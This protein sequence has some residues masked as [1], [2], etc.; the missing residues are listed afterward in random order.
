V[1]TK[2][3]KAKQAAL[4][5]YWDDQGKLLGCGHGSLEFKPLWGRGEATQAEFLEYVQKVLNALH[6]TVMGNGHRHGTVKF[7][8]GRSK[9]YADLSTWRVNIDH[10]WRLI[11]ENY[12]WNWTQ[13]DYSSKDGRFEQRWMKNFRKASLAFFERGMYLP[14][15]KEPPPPPSKVE[16][17]ARKIAALEERRAKW[18]VKQERA[19]KWI[20]KIDRSLRALARHQR[21]ETQ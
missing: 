19:R 15:T 12:S 16:S 11:V 14:E 13:G 10:S 17:R 20:I 21:K 5:E 9:S 4:H 18:E 3:G 7:V 2:A 6:R 1:I 8:T